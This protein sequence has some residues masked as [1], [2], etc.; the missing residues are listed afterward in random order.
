MARNGQTDRNIQAGHKAKAKA[1]SGV[2]MQ[3]PKRMR[4]GSIVAKPS[5]YM[6]T[7]PIRSTGKTIKCE[8]IDMAHALFA[9]DLDMG[10]AFIYMA[11]AGKKDKSSYIE[12]LAKAHYWL[13]MAIEWRGGHPEV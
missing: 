8:V 2:N 9:G 4:K 12:D 5:H 6:V 7:M 3:L 11:R 13:G 10:T 1:K